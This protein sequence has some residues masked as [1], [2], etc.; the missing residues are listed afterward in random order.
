MHASTD[1]SSI[2]KPQEPQH[3]VQGLTNYSPQDKFGLPPI[4]GNK[5]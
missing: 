3:L 1:S 2:F 4:F 5:V